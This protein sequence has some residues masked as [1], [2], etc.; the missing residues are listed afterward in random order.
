MVRQAPQFF[1]SNGTAKLFA[2][3]GTGMIVTACCTSGYLFITNIEPYKYEIRSPVFLTILFAIAALPVAWAFMEFFEKAANTIL[4]C[5]CVELD[6]NKKQYKCPTGLKH[7]MREY[8][9]E[10]GHSEYR[11]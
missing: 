2:I 3:V 8:Q 11:R 6:L 1:V 7:F 9:D 5:Y 4:M 10:S